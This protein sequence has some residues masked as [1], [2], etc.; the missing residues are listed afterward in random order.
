VTAIEPPMETFWDL[1]P[2]GGV[3]L[4]QNEAFSTLV[5]RVRNSLWYLHNVY[6]SKVE[7]YEADAYNL[8]QSLGSFDV[9]V[10][11]A[12]L[13]HCSS[14]ARMIASI[15]GLGVKELIVSEPYHPGLGDEPV[16]RLVPSLQNDSIDAWWAF[17]P[18]FFCQYFEV[19]GF[20]KVTVTRHRQFFSSRQQFVDMFTVVGS[21]RAVMRPQAAPSGGAPLGQAVAVPRK[22]T[23]PSAGTK[24]E[25]ILRPDLPSEPVFSRIGRRYAAYLNGTISEQISPHDDMY[26]GSMNAYMGVGRSAIEIICCAMVAAKRD[27]YDSILDLPCGGGRVTRH[28]TAF[29]EGSEIFVCDANKERQDFVARTFGAKPFAA[30][31]DFSTLPTRKFD[32]IFVGSLLTHLDSTLFVQAMEYFIGALAQDGLLIVTTHGRRNIFWQGGRAAGHLQE[33]LRDF[34]NAGFGFL[35]LKEEVVEGVRFP[36]GGTFIAPSWLLRKVET[37]SRIRVIEFREGAWADNQDVLVLQK[38]SMVT[39]ACSMLSIHNSEAS[40]STVDF[41]E[42][43][44]LALNPDVARAVARGEFACGW[45]HFVMFGRAEGRKTSGC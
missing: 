16:C 30:P 21:D 4:T 43:D 5:Q 6:E 25:E 42:S 22:G 35:K 14:P 2:R 33:A 9:G 1:V 19:L 34:D 38:H 29:F 44:Y 39:A 31:P 24:R 7:L 10:L 8:P 27:H 11:A 40:I 18:A 26:E 20:G 15:A 13:L 45:D 36:Y 12:V 37:D 41:S 3:D 17:S 32:L 28:L 23:T